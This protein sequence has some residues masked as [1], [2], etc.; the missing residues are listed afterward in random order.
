MTTIDPQVRSE[1]LALVNELAGD[2]E[3]EQAITPDTYFL[4][5]LGLESLDLVVLGTMV[6]QR[7]GKLPF[8]EWLAEIGQRPVDQRDVTV[9]ELV[10]YVCA[11]RPPSN[12]NGAG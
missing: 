12:W 6:Q 7:Y 1:V 5:D 4:G 2:W 3:Y 10:S 11:H 8:S 9:G